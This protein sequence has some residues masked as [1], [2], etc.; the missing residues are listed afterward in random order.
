MI[1]YIERKVRQYVLVQWILIETARYNLFIKRA[2][3]F[4]FK[5]TWIEL[6]LCIKRWISWRSIDWYIFQTVIGYLVKYLVLLVLLLKIFRVHKYTLQ[7]KYIYLYCNIVLK[8]WYLVLIYLSTSTISTKCTLI[9]C[10]Q[11]CYTGWILWSEPKF[12]SLI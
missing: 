10:R 8:Y 12:G 11:Y 4:F 6:E 2:I 5:I 1:K 7:Y 9:S 3:V